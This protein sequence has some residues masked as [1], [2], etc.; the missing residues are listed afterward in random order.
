M[1]T[2]DNS[3]CL[4]LLVTGRQKTPWAQLTEQA[5][6]DL[7]QVRYVTPEQAQEELYRD[8]YNVAIVDA[9]NVQ[10]VASL[11]R[12]LLADRADL[13]VVVFTASP[14]WKRA[15]EALQAGAVDYC[16]KSLDGDEIR[17][18]IKF[19]LGLPAHGAT[20]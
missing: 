2:A 19:A 14:T 16:R 15:R 18:V 17:S 12:S 4:F 7:G 1:T 9:G 8:R 6:A 20:S 3:T 13:R 11:T 5:L 10:D